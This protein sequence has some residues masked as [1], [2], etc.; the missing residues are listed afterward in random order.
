MK[1][2][3]KSL[4]SKNPFGFLLILVLYF[5]NMSRISSVPHA[6]VYKQGLLL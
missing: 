3:D 6:I 5:S 1:I 2:I 4:T